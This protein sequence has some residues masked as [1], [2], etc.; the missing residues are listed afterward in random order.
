MF[1]ELFILRGLRTCFLDLLI[2]REIVLFRFSEMGEAGSEISGR[3]EMPRRAITFE[4]SLPFTYYFNMGV[5][6]D[7]A[8]APKDGAPGACFS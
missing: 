2:V 4:L 5:K 7:F 6:A 1:L 8:R 3:T